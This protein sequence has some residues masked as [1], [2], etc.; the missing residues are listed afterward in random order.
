MAV[1]VKRS[2]PGLRPNCLSFPEVFAQAIGHISPAGIAAVGIPTVFASTGNG[3]WL[4]FVI[5]TIGLVLIGFNINQF[6]RRSVSTGLLYTAVARN[7]GS[8][9]GILTGWGL[10]AAYLFNGVAIAAGFVMYTN[11]LL[12]EFGVQLPPILLF[13]ICIGIVWYCAYT[14][15]QLSSIVTLALEG[16]SMILIVCLAIAV[17]LK[18]GFT[19][20]I[21]QFSLQGVSPENLRLGLVLAVFSYVGFE[22]PTIFGYE[23]KRPFRLVPRAVIWS[24]VLPGLLYI[25]L[26]YTEILG[27]RNYATPLDKTDVPLDALANLTGLGLL[28]I[29][30]SAGILCSFLSGV[31]VATNAGARVLYAMSRHHIMPWSLGKAHPKNETPHVAVTLFIILL[32]VITTVMSLFGVSVLDIY[33]ST[34]TFSTYGFLM[35]Y[36]LVSISAP[37]ELRRNGNLQQRDVIIAVLAVL[38]VLIPVIG[39]LYP[40]PPFPYNILPYLFVAYLVA[41]WW[42]FARGKARSPEL[43]ADMKLLTADMKRGF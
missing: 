24:V 27:F 29:A 33:I 37:M 39:S 15:V 13:G 38:F 8:T 1:Q 31:L 26:S 40:V 43:A 3:T 25:L 23:A 16:I 11:V 42:F 2:V 21:A 9:A 12:Q 10:V 7:L 35:T 4:A 28:G 22:T 32:F 41:G 36:L 34:S 17:L 14:D 20:D 19:L 18:H 5:A 30:I 6:A